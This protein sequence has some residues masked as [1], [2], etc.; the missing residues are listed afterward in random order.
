MPDNLTKSTIMEAHFFKCSFPRKQVRERHIPSFPRKQVRQRYFH[1]HSKQKQFH[2]APFTITQLASNSRTEKNKLIDHQSLQ[3]KPGT[4]PSNGNEGNQ[5]AN[6]LAAGVQSCPL[7]TLPSWDTFGCHQK[8][9]HSNCKRDSR[10]ECMHQENFQ[11]SKHTHKTSEPTQS[12]TDQSTKGSAY[13]NT[14]QS[15]NQ[16]CHMLN[17]RKWT[18]VTRT[19]HLEIHLSTGG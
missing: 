18:K 10:F 3:N 8:S 15:T 16:Y 1:W 17:K 5:A 12:C 6:S 13:T 11:Q 4:V 9:Q 7:P 2:L 19:L 14:N